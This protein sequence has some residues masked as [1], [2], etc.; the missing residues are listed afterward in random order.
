MPL[1]AIKQVSDA[2]DK[3]AAIRKDAYDQSKRLLAQAERDGR[4]MLEEARLQAE[5]E[6]ARLLLEAE[7]PAKK[8]GEELLAAAQ[9]EGALLRAKAEGRMEKAV[10]LITERIVNG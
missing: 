7:G 8:Q 1:E 9:R 6:A 2:E 5:A 10:Q 3:A 4:A